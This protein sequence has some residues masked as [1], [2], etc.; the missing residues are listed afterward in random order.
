MGGGMELAL[1]ADL[2]VAGDAVKG[3][4]LTE[5]KLGIIPG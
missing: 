3:L 1:C 5:V 4:G 2:R